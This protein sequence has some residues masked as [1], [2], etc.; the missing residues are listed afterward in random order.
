MLIFGHKL[1]PSKPFIWQRENFNK[2]KIVC[3][4]Y[5]ESL[6]QKA[7]Q[8]GIEFCIFAQNEDEIL[9]ANALKAS[10]IVIDDDNLAKKASKMAEFYLFDSKI[11]LLIEEFKNLSLAYHLGVDGVICKSYIQ[12]L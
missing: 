12:G 5:D 3:F 8:D 7:L 10:Y 1:L 9:L 2:D 6:V 4:D 11:L